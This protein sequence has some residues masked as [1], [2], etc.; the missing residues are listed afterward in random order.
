MKKLL[1][2]GGSGLLGAAIVYELHKYFEVYA[3]YHNNQIT[4]KHASCI[5]LDLTNKDEAE[6]L[7]EKIKPDIIIHT[8]AMTD[9]DL[10]E[11]KPELAKKINVGATEH[12]ANACKKEG[13]K[14]VHISTDYVFDGEKGNYKESDRMN[15]VDIYAKTKAEAEGLVKCVKAAL[16]I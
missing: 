5:K 11:L 14:L 15:P 1:V 6:R 9:V 4:S 2:T 13:I 7:I 10:C 3:T 12:I 16:I 8:A